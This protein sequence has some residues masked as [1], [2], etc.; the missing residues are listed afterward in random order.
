M[1]IDCIIIYACKS[2]LERKIGVKK[3]KKS[4]VWINDENSGVSE[5]SILIKLDSSEVMI[6]RDLVIFPLW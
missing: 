2:D 1:D 6:R 4:Q 3:T 5:L